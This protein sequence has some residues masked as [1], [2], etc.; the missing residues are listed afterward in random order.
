MKLSQ[1]EPY[2]KYIFTSQLPQCH[3]LLEKLKSL[4]KIRLHVDQT[5]I[6]LKCYFEGFVEFHSLSTRALFE[7]SF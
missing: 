7:C 6:K 3:S 5:S 4:I 1:F 2:L